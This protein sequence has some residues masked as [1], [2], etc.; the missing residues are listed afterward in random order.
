MEE[1]LPILTKLLD[2]GLLSIADKSITE[3]GSTCF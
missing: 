3:D 1:L 2:S